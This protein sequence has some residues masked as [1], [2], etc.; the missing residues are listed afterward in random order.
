MNVVMPVFAALMASSF[1]LHPALKIALV[2]LSVSP[3]PPILPNKALKAGGKGS[4]I[5]G[6]L[7]AMS[8]LAIVVVPAAL[9]VSQKVFGV[10]L[11]MSPSA[12]AFIVVST[13]LAPLLAGILV[14]RIAEDF[15]LK[16]AKPIGLLSTVM[17]V[18]GAIPILLTTIS[19]F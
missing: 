2:A 8:L 6:L 16:F 11:G 18:A 19:S 15:A 1:A 13:I 5:V 7:V 10:S 12:V 9:E 3:I 4:Y 17:L 14:H